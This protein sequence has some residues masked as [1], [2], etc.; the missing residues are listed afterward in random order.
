MAISL[1]KGGN[2]SLSKEAP[3]LDRIMVGLGWDVRATDG[4]DFD[5]DASAFLCNAGGK[6][7]TDM[8]FC[9]YN[10]M[11]VA[12]GAVI[13]QG[14]NRTGEG[15]GDDEQIEITLSKLPAD[16]DKV[17]VVVTIHDGD[18]NG[19]TFG[20]VSNA[21]IRLVDANTNKEV[22]RYDLSEDASV[23]TAM[24]LGEVYRHG[25]DWKFRAVGQGFKGGLGPLAGHFGVNVG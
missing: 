19:Q 6:V 16:V 8:D 18:R 4:Q 14:D 7:R 9:F 25:G 17:A 12:G 20:Q 5:L 22:V 23:E 15:E 21:F 1:S 3:G 13:H 11:N 24:I 10:N 2:V